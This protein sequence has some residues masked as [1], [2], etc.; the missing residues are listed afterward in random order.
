MGNLALENFL[1][2]MQMHLSEI[3]TTYTNQT[4]LTSFRVTAKEINGMSGKYAYASMLD[5]C[6]LISDFNLTHQFNEMPLV[7]SLGYGFALHV[8]NVQYKDHYI[9]LFLTSF[10][11]SYN[12]NLYLKIQG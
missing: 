5:P 11:R 2:Q 1:S 4:T 3:C 7:N 12:C 8:I 10:P 6:D 9:I